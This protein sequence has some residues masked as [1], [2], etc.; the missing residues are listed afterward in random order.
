MRAG[1][2]GPLT[3]LDDGTLTRLLEM[4]PTARIFRDVEEKTAILF[5][6]DE[7]VSY[8]AGAVKK[9]LLKAER[10]G[11]GVLTDL[12]SPLAEMPE[13]SP[14]ALEELIRSYAEKRELGLGK[15]AQPLRVAV[16]GTTVSPPIF[17]TLA[18]LGR[19]RT[20]ARIDRMLETHRVASAPPRPT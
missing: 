20:L 15:V 11:V 4:N 17:D 6:P 1:E 18:L 3:D 14:A 9:W 12:R 5:Q 19:E 8:D 13:F 2:R 10:L 7:Q 16:T